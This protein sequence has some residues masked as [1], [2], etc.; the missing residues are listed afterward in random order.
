MKYGSHFTNLFL[1]EG[2]PVSQYHLLSSLHLSYGKE[3]QSV[4][5]A[6]S[7]LSSMPPTSPHPASHKRHT[8]LQ[9]KV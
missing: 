8:T 3:L 6:I 9:F 1:E 2:Y 4:F 7:G 5:E